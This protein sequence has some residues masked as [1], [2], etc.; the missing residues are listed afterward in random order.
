MST[1]WYVGYIGYIISGANVANHYNSRFIYAHFDGYPDRVL[2][3]LRK[4]VKNRN[5]VLNLMGIDFNHP[6]GQDI[7]GIEE[8]VQLTGK[9]KK[10]ILKVSR[11]ENPSNKL[12]IETIMAYTIN[13]AIASLKSWKKG[14]N[15]VYLFDIE[16]EEWFV[17]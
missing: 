12:Y 1:R 13:E 10:P 7:Q 11:I 14:I 15:Y 8:Q 5:Q 16:E 3:L 2:P 4:Y 6:N 17:G 9:Q